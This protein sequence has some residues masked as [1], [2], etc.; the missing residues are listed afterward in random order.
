MLMV[1]TD[2]CLCLESQFYYIQ[3]STSQKT[4]TMSSRFLLAK[5]I[6]AQKPDAIPFYSLCKP[7]VFFS[8]HVEILTFFF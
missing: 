5:A 2:L 6:T 7:L 3:Y 4:V 8:L 1:S